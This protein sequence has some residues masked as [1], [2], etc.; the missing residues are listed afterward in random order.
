MDRKSNDSSRSLI[1]KYGGERERERERRKTEKIFALG[2]LFC[3][4][5]G[6]R[7]AATPSCLWNY[8]RL[9]SPFLKKKKLPP[10]R[11]RRSASSR[12]RWPRPRPTGGPRAP[13]PRR[14]R[15]P[16]RPSRR[17]R[18]RRRRR[19]LLAQQLPREISRS[20]FRNR[21]LSLV[22]PL[23]PNPRFSVDSVGEPQKIRG[24]RAIFLC[25]F[26]R[27]RARDSDACFFSPVFCFQFSKHNFWQRANEINY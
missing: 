20:E 7:L 15:L 13:R 3:R 18:E 5:L 22:M 17:R 26:A 25:N 11:Y 16:P 1:G 2:R 9:T 12:L 4:R 14:P 27:A 19:P 21:T 23:K 6:S 10:N 8:L 24:T